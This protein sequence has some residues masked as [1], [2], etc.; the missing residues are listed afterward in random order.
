MK[1]KLLFIVVAALLS[2]ASVFAQ[3]VD[4]GTTGSLTWE[5]TGTEPNYTLT[6]SG[7]GAMPDYEWEGNDMFSAFGTAPWFEYH[8]SIATVVIEKGVTT[9][10][11]FAFLRYSALTSITISSS[12]TTIG[13]YA[14]CLCS[15]L[16]SV[17][18]PNNVI[19]IS[20]G[21]FSNCT[22]LTSITITNGVTTIGSGAFGSC[23]ALTSVTLPNSVATIGNFAF[24]YCTALT[25]VT[26]E[27]G[28]ITIEGAAFFGCSALTSIIIPNSITTIGNSAFFACTALTSINVDSENPNYSSD[29]GVFFNKDKTNLLQYPAGK[30]NNSY[31]VPNSVT[32]IERDA[33]FAC[34]ALASITLPNSVAI[35]GE[36]AF[37]YCTTLTS[38]TALNL[39]PVGIDSSVFQEVNRSACILTVPTS[40]VLAYQEAEVWQ[41]FNI[42]GGGILVNPVSGNQEQGYTIGEGLYQPGKGETATITAVPYSGYKFINWTKDSAEVSTENPY[43][44]TVTEDVELVANFEDEVGIKNLEV[45]DIKIYP[46]PTT[47]KLKIENGELK[48]ENIEIY[49]IYGRNVGAKFPSNKLE[50]WQPQADGVVFNISHLPS[51][52][53]FV[54]IT[55]ESGVVVKKVVKE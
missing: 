55:T 4:G 15:M 17:S 20:D 18:I 9:I 30:T 8:E 26:L 51:G 52:I 29:D 42:I 21:A 38:V 2:T 6:I 33:F 45:S 53:Y 48:I 22:A 36:G 44:F 12:V 1:K 19:T 46:N 37:A 24:F 50:G 27:N 40:A 32:T 25:S 14:F 28:I 41:D 7:N 31:T 49:D 43:S 35:I 10:G 16:V 13:N 5:V 11:N 54:I 23:Y 39:T 47:G 34:T 3:Y